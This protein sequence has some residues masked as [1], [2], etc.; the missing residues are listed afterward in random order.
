MF[1]DACAG[2]GRDGAGRR[3]GY[4][5]NGYLQQQN[6]TE[7]ELFSIKYIEATAWK[8]DIPSWAPQGKRFIWI[9]A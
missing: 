9:R 1:A 3:D 4:P 8:E 7:R 2:K 5:C 6:G